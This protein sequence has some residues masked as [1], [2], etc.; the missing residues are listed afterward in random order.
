MS[1]NTKKIKLLQDWHAP[2]RLKNMAGVYTTRHLVEDLEETL[3]QFNLPK[4]ELKFIIDSQFSFMA[5]KIK[6][7]DYLPVKL[8]YI[9]KFI[10]KPYLNVETLRYRAKNK[11]NPYRDRNVLPEADTATPS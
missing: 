3:S 4:E 5:A 2:D 8:K 11:I 7:G 1:N 10:V 9:G 6:S